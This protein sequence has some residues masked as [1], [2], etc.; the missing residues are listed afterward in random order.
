MSAE[1]LDRHHHRRIPFEGACNCRDLGGLNTTD[2]RRTRRGVV[3]RSDALATLSVADQA[4]L[5]ELGVR[6][7]Y[8]LRTTEERAR[9]PNRLPVPPPAQHPFGFLPRGNPEMFEGV[10]SGAWSPA[11]TR[12]SMLGQYERLILDHTD[13]LAKVYRGL[14]RDDGIPAVVHCASGKDRTGIASA[15]LLLAVGV[16][17]DAVVEDY[18]ISNFQR[19]PVELF[20]GGAPSEAVEQIMCASADYITHA[21]ATAER[22]FGSF[23]DFLAQGVG[24]SDLE[25]VALAEL[26]V[27]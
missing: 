4:A 19:R 22:S 7:V 23:D 18:V 27:D 25:R 1:L 14:L 5:A 15:V 17:R 11:Q 26:L 24:L 16:D 10:N 21:L 13:C 12:Q 3:Y 8:D 2:G 9:Y 6:A 20:V